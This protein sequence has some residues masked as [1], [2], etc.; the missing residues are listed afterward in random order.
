[1]KLVFVSGFKSIASG[2]STSLSECGAVCVNGNYLSKQDV[3]ALVNLGI[4]RLEEEVQVVPLAPKFNSTAWG[5]IKQAMVDEK[6]SYV[7]DAEYEFYSIEDEEWKTSKLLKTAS[8]IGRVA[9]G[10]AVPAGSSERKKF[11]RLE[12]LNEVYELGLT[13]DDVREITGFYD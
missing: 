12:K 13:R 7:F 3:S 11:N 1:M 4:A 5:K 6:N 9:A 8:H 10:F 2:T